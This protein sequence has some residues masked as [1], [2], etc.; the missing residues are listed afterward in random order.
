MNNKFSTQKL[1]F[2]IFFIPAVVLVSSFNQPPAK[3]KL[4][5]MT[6]AEAQTAMKTNPKPL[7]IDLYTDWCGWCKVMDKNTYSNE[8]VITYVEDKFYPV[9]LDAETK[10]SLN[11]NGR[12]FKYNKQY[13]INEIAIYF[14]GGDLSFPTTI[15]VN[16]KTADPQNI[17]GYMKP[18]EL[19]PIAKYFGEGKFGKQSFES[20]QQNFKS[21]W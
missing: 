3:A 13:R 11:W 4:K 17:A 15:F 1:R 20:F 9:K 5:W 8:K 12:V 6:L 14:T 18:S 10:D 2:L 7:L 19:E 16:D 21:E